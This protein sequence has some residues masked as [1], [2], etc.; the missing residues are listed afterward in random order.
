MEL[1]QALS[2]VTDVFERRGCTQERRPPEDGAEFGMMQVTSQECEGLPGHTSNSQE[3]QEDPSLK[4]SEG[5]WPCPANIDFGLGA[6]RTEKICF[7]C[8]KP[9]SLLLQQP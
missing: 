7:C 6:S 9:Q 3:A 4:P 8:F 2:P 1:G 5:A